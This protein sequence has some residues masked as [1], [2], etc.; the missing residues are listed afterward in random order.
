LEDG[1]FLSIRKILPEAASLI[2]VTGYQAL[3]YTR[4]IWETHEG[5]V[6]L[7]VNFTLA[8][9]DL[10]LYTYYIKEIFKIN[11]SLPS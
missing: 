5:L 6:R 11:F 1:T 8:E 9:D 3:G 10:M 4:T 7:P 2:I